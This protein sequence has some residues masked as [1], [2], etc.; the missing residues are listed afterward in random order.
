MKVLF[1]VTLCL[2]LAAC[3]GGLW[4]NPYPTADDGKSILY[5]AFTERPKHLD[6]AQAYSENEYEFL[7]L[8]YAPPLQYHYLKRPYQLTPLAASVLPTVSYLDKNR[9]PLPEKAAAERIAYSVY[10]I[11]IKPGMRYQPHPAFV[12]ANSLRKLDSI[13]SLADF[14]ATATREVTAADYAYQIKRLVHPQLHTPIAGVMSEY[15]VGLKDYAA[16]LQAAFRAHPDE[17]LDLNQYPLSG[18]E[19][20]D[21]TTYRITVHGKYPQFA[22]WLAMPFFSPMPQEVERFYALPGMKERNLTLDWWPVGSG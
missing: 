3:D 11:R 4:N 16:A 6:P 12:P 1:S 18:V 5:S 21:D 10:E 13:A 15:I 20:L 19:V 2:L 8:V 14:A 17:F 7:A 22:Y 9:R